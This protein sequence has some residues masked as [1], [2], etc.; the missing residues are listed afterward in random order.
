MAQSSRR[1]CR[2]ETLSSGNAW[3]LPW[4]SNGGEGDR[5]FIVRQEPVSAG[6]SPKLLSTISNLAL[7]IV[8]VLADNVRWATAAE[9]GAGAGAKTSSTEADTRNAQRE[10]GREA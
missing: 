1:E 2:Y 4:V 7:F 10:E 9:Y 6:E 3:Q 8:L 5:F